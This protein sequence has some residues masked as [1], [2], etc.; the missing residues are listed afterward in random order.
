MPAKICRI[1]CCFSVWLL[2]SSPLIA[3]TDPA[4]ESLNPLDQAVEF[5]QTYVSPVDGPRC[6]MQPTCSVYA[7]QALHKHG[8]WMGMFIT[9]D[10]LLREIDP[11]E[12][13]PP[14]LSGGTLR[15]A[16]PLSANDFWLLPPSPASPRSNPADP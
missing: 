14:T 5:F 12:G 10:R 7:R 2:T 13:Q 1:I 3:A 6:R 8:F 15:Y 11:L 16:D 4:D 9:V